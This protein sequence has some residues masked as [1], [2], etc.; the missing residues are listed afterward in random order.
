MDET[1]I[2]ANV[3]LVHDKFSYKLPFHYV[4]NRPHLNEFLL[5]ANG[6]ILLAVWS[7]ATDDY[8]N[9]I[10][11]NSFPEEIKLLLLGTGHI[12]LRDLMRN[13]GSL[14]M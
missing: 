5:Q 6:I 13:Y 4:Y 8:V 1:L 2:H 11:K 7:S 9:D 10:I 3:D 14:Y 12:A